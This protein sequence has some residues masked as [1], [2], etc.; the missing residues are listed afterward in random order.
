[1]MTFIKLPEKTPNC[2]V[3]TEMLKEKPVTKDQTA[4]VVGNVREIMEVTP[5][6]FIRKF[7]SVFRKKIKISKDIR[8]IVRIL[9]LLFFYRTVFV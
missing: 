5:S 9:V 2:L 7:C 1:M 3:E 4:E 8:F 6:T